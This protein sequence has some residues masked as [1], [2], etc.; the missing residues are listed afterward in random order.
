ML[1]EY[2]TSDW[3]RCHAIN[4]AGGIELLEWQD[5]IMRGWL[6]K[7][8]LGRWAASTCGGS[9]ARQNG[10]SLGLVVPRVNYGMTCLREDV[11]YT[12][13]LQ[14]TSTETFETVATFFD[15][16]ALKKHVKDIKTALGR[17]QVILKNGGRIKFLAR[18]RNGGRGQHGDLLIFDEALELSAESQS[19]FLP[20]ISASRNPQ[21]IYVSSPPTPTSDSEV[22]RE[23]RS[24]ALLGVSSRT[25]WF[26]WSVD[27]ENMDEIDVNDRSLWYATN[28]SLG[29]LIQ[30]STVEGEVE[31]MSPDTFARERLGWWSPTAGQLAHPIDEKQW[32]DLATDD[33]IADGRVAYGVKFAADG[34]EVCVCAAVADGGTVHV[35]EVER[36]NMAAGTAWLAEWIAE[37]KSKGCRCVI[38]GKAGAQALVD[39]LE[40]MPKGYIHV[41][42]VND[43]YSAASTL[44][45]CVNERNLTWYAPQADLRDS[46]VTSIRRNIGRDGGWGFGGANP[47]PIEAAALAVW[48]V[49]T[50]RRNP[51]RKGLV[52]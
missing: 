13:H 49:R 7:N 47:I 6:G 44:L 52:G 2:A 17:E 3:E 45:N 43:M 14:K 12:S 8:T 15:Q 32:D 37:R 38:D 51:Q 34:S 29:I 1:P 11:L 42:G 26:E 33:P 22:F 24:R 23:I 31:Q 30:E 46:A 19:S 25:A 5:G 50:S 10:K 16:S 28:P 40:R 20:A 21:V 9:L 41:A 18:T 35:E 4:A 48:G 36:R 39:R 27:S